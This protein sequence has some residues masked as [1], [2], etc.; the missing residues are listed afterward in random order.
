M[1]LLPPERSGA[2]PVI[3]RRGDR[4]VRD[5]S[6]RDPSALDPA[7]SEWSPHPV[8]VLQIS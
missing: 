2:L 8:G 1:K 4:R 7:V 3:F 5:L 6:S